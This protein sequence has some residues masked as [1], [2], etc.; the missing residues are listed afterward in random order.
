[1]APSANQ[2]PVG[3]TGFDSDARFESY[4]LFDSDSAFK[5][6]ARFDSNT[7]FDGAGRPTMRPAMPRRKGFVV[8]ALVVVLLGATLALVLTDLHGRAQVQQTDSNLAAADHQLSAA[9][10][11]LQV[12][13]AETD[14]VG[15][16]VRAVAANVLQAQSS[17]DR[18]AASISSTD[19]GLAS[20]GVNIS[21]LNTCLGGVTNALDQIAVGLFPGALSSLS[22]VS[23]SCNAARPASG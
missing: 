17:V 6:D 16:A 11:Q 21:Q 5:S 22:S 1:M 15:T 9:R 13:R 14:A 7:G 19:M 10:R 23:A 20:A 12:T 8:T 18:T 3:D 4:A 2:Q